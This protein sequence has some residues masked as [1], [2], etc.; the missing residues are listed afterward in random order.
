MLWSYRTSF[1]ATAG[2]TPFSLAYRVE[3]V[4]PVEINLPTF[5]VN[6]FNEEKNDVLLALATDLLE[7]KREI[8]QVQAAALQETIAQYYNSKVKLRRFAKGDLVLRKVFLNTKEKGVSVL[9][10]NW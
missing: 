10:P 2:E 3:A 1:R 9:G 6:N 7:E 5:R 4:I 8:S